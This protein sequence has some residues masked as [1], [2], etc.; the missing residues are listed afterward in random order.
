MK[1]D[2]VIFTDHPGL[3]MVWKTLGAYTI[4]NV[5]RKLG[6]TCLVIDHL[7]CFS[8]QEIEKILELSVSEQTKFVG[9][10]VGFFANT[11]GINPLALTTQLEY[12]VMNINKSFCPQGKNFED[13]LVAKI[14][15][16]NNQCKIVIGGAQTISH[17]ISNKNIDYLVIGYAEVSVVNLMRHLEGNEQLNKSYKNINGITIIDDRAASDYDLSACLMDWLPED[18]GHS[19][20]LPL[21]G[22]RGCI[23]N[24]KFCQFPLRN[25]KTDEHLRS[26]ESIYQELQSNYDRYG[27]TAYTLLDDTFNDDDTKL[28]LFLAAVKRLTFQPIFW[29]YA[30]TDLFI[31]KPD[32]LQK[33][34]DIGVRAMFL[35]IETL[36]RK[37]GL[38]VG[39]GINVDRQLNLIQNIR[40]KYG[41]D[42]QLNGSFIVGL[43]H[44]SLESIDNTC[45]LFVN[46]ELPLHSMKFSALKINKDK[47]WWQSDF[48]KDYTKHG[49][50]EYPQQ[51]S[52]IDLVATGYTI[53][54]DFLAWKNDYMTFATA[55]K[56]TQECN[57][58]MLESPYMHPHG[59]MIMSM[60]NYDGY[61][62]D[63]LKD[64]RL[65]DID[66][67][68]LVKEKQKTLFKY[69]RFLNSILTSQTN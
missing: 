39:K 12:G 59:Q 46:G 2:C 28:D 9:F 58:R 54:T 36:N 38:A 34:Y 56:K 1:Y 67:N 26:A 13:R 29:C 66:F 60:L 50:V 7:H 48:E 27:I 14:K 53:N 43:P 41:N 21:E 15:Q 44:E 42:L 52:E 47:S 31:S 49:Y 16:L 19:K 64:M 35:G 17:Q 62:F 57:Q 68:Q 8:P 24:C 6:Y 40:S 3:T 10:S 22:S 5:L 30:R 20:V 37:T 69:K 18:I 45:N 32:R 11:E 25:K 61:S 65:K 23:F 55:I 4:A 51:L 33:V 63:K